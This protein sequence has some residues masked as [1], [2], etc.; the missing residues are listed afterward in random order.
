MS[1][2]RDTELQRL[3][4]IQSEFAQVPRVQ[5]EMGQH[6][7]FFGSARPKW[8]DVEYDFT[9][10]L[11]QKLAVRGWDILT[12]GGPGLMEAANLGCQAG[13][14][15]SG[16]CTLSGLPGEQKPN[17]YLDAE[18]HFSHFYARKTA[19]VRYASAY[20]VCPGGAGTADELFE[21]FT[22]MQNAKMPRRPMLFVGD[23]WRPL[24]VDVFGA[25]ITSGYVATEE[26]TGVYSVSLDDDPHR[27]A[28]FL[29]DRAVQFKEGHV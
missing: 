1:H 27:V 7:T 19:L 4:R 16:G 14:G 24:L 8:G 18:F 17:I 21:V 12:G 3:I 23:F 22:L 6:I 28:E 9:V 10:E 5:Q 11:A 26:T 2:W 25:M 20:V 15:F 13:G 29:E